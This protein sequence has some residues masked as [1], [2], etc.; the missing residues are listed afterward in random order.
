MIV[1]VRL[2]LLLKKMSPFLT[3]TKYLFQRPKKAAGESD[4]VWYDTFI[5]HC[6]LADKSKKLSIKAKPLVCK[7]T[8]QPEPLQPQYVTCVDSK[9][10]VSWHYLVTGVKAVSGVMLPKHV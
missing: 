9:P 5:D 4:E 7:Q 8:T 3:Q 1:F 6:M 2:V 10:G